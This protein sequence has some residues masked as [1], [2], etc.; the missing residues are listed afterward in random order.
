MGTQCH[1]FTILPV[2][3]LWAALLT[4]SL[5]TPCKD[6]R[7]CMA[8]IGNFCVSS[9]KTRTTS[10][11]PWGLTKPCSWPRKTLTKDLFSLNIAAIPVQSMPRKSPVPWAPQPRNMM[12]ARSPCARVSLLQSQAGSLEGAPPLLTSG[13]SES[14]SFPCIPHQSSQPG[15]GEQLFSA[16]GLEGSQ[17]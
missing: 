8:D 16:P 5:I 10:G 13:I 12:Q 17:G 15:S 14:P 4:I 11:C 6:T 9:A 2:G 3:W 7:V 1:V